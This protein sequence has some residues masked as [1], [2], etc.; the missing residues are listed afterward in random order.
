MQQRANEAELDRE[1]KQ[2]LMDEQVAQRREATQ[3]RQSF[4]NARQTEAD[5]TAKARQDVATTAQQRAALQDKQMLLQQAIQLNSTG[6]LTDEGRQNFNDWLS[7]DEHFGVTGLQLQA[8]PQ[9][10]PPQAGQNSVAGALQQ[11]DKWRQ[12]AA[13]LADGDPNKDRFNKYADTLEGSVDPAAVAEISQTVGGDLSGKG[14]ITIKRKVPS[15]QVQT[16]APAA[17]AAPGLPPQKVR[18]QRS[19]GSFGF[20]P[21]NQVQ[22]ALTAGYKLA[23]LPPAPGTQ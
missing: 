20:V 9:K 19:D 5:A 8:P 15:S 6:Q 23:P 2:Q 18:M 11:A 21:G 22:T 16:Q 17:G 13:G 12:Q 7:G 3:A 14:G 1:M 10:A 4:Y